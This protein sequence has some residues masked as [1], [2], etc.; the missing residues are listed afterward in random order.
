[1]S[2][3]DLRDRNKGDYVEFVQ[4]DADYVQRQVDACEDFLKAIRL[5]LKSP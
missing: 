2:G 4:F 5:L 1:M 3:E